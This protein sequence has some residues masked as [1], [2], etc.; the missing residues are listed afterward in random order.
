LAAGQ[1]WWITTRSITSRQK[2]YAPVGGG[3]LGCV[4]KCNDSNVGKLRICTSTHAL[5]IS[6][7][8]Y[9][10]GVIKSSLLLRPATFSSYILRLL[11]GSDLAVVLDVDVLVRG[12]SVDLVLGE[13][14]ATS[15]QLR[16]L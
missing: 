10:V 14:S 11:L 4:L 13:G 5:S 8:C 16:S 9:F 7:P 12:Q 3:G 1:L 15:G 2:H 6:L